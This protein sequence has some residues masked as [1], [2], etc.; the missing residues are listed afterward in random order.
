MAVELNKEKG[1]L[2]S[3]SSHPLRELVIE[4]FDG[5]VLEETRK[6][7]KTQNDKPSWGSLLSKLNKT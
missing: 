2:R 3:P 7:T 5:V 1:R 4:L 6:A